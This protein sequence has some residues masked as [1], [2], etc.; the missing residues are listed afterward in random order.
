MI[1]LRQK[2]VYFQMS[3]LYH[4]TKCPSFISVNTSPGV[5]GLPQ[6]KF[7]LFAFN[8]IEKQSKTQSSP[9]S[10]SY[11]LADKKRQVI[12]CRNPSSPTTSLD[13]SLN[14]STFANRQKDLLFTI[15]LF[16]LPTE[17]RN[18]TSGFGSSQTSS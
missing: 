10:C 11:S 6:L 4:F 7:K 12:G 16:S 2:H 3:H 15:L 13:P 14:S 8:L 17:C 18:F 1:N 9:Q 5:R